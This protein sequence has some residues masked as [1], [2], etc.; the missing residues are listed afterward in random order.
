M[1][2]FY[3][4]RFP[5]LLAYQ[6]TQPM[7]GYAQAYLYGKLPICAILLFLLTVNFRLVIDKRKRLLV[8][9][10]YIISVA[11]PLNPRRCK[12]ITAM[13]ASARTDTLACRISIVTLWISIAEKKY[14]EH[15]YKI[16]HL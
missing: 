14:T 4:S 16:F 5:Q 11:I 1:D 8:Y 12:V 3:C 15:K 7:L 2:S 6:P 10:T 9:L 13:P